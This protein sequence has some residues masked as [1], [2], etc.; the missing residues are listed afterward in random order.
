MAIA[1][2]PGTVWLRA[3]ITASTK[4]I[5]ETSDRSVS[6][7]QTPNLTLAPAMR[8]LAAIARQSARAVLRPHVWLTGGHEGDIRAL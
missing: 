2:P 1:F 4:K 3:A 5:A 8:Q 7:K 6:T